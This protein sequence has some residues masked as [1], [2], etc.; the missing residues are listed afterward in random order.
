M[1]VVPLAIRLNVMKLFRIYIPSDTKV[2]D[3]HKGDEIWKDAVFVEQLYEFNG[4]HVSDLIEM[5]CKTGVDKC[6]IGNGF[7]FNENIYYFENLAIII[8]VMAQFLIVMIYFF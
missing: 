8:R 3:A 7:L 2:C 6:T 5:F 1:N 4:K